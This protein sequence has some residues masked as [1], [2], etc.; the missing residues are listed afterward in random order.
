MRNGGVESRERRNNGVRGHPLQVG[1]LTL[2]FLRGRWEASE[3]MQSGR[4]E[5]SLK[6]RDDP[7]PRSQPALPIWQGGGWRCGS[8]LGRCGREG[9]VSRGA[10]PG[11]RGTSLFTAKAGRMTDSIKV[12]KPSR[13]LGSPRNCGW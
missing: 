4:I 9:G 5:N 10:K 13:H 6:S 1:V 2:A 3:G 7:V 8:R 12:P 11:P